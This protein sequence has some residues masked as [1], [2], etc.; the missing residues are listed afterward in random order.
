MRLTAIGCEKLLQPEQ[1]TTRMDDDLA[2]FIQ[3]MYLVEPKGGDDDHT[4]IIAA[5][6]GRTFRQAGI[7]RLQDNNAIGGDHRLKHSPHFHETTGDRDKDCL[8]LPRAKPF[9]KTLCLP[10]SGQ[11]MP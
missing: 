6:R 9:A 4:A 10:L 8:P 2:S 3:H 7:R 1:C 5:F 11:A